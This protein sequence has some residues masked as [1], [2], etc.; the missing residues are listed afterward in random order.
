MMN[1]KDYELLMK[2]KQKKNIKLLKEVY[3]SNDDCL[4]KFEYG[5][6]LVNNGNR[7]EGK[8]ILLD[9]AQNENYWLAKLELGKLE[10]S[11]MNTKMARY[12]LESLLNTYLENSAFL[13]LSK[14]EYKI[15]NTEKSKGYLETL[16]GTELEVYAYILLIILEI[17]KHD[18]KKAVKTVNEA[19]SNGYNYSDQI[20][21][22]LSKKL[23]IFFDI[24]Y[25]KYYTS[26]YTIKQ[27]L[28]Y[29]E[30]LALS[31][32][33]GRHGG[34][35]FNRKINIK[36]LYVDIQKQLIKQNKLNF[37]H[38]NDIYVV[39]FENIGNQNEKYLEIVTLP[40]S[41][42]IITMFPIGS[43]YE[44]ENNDFDEFIKTI[45]KKH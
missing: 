42:E 44:A 28:S 1:D 10:I 12:Y 7:K 38:F 6:F 34:C 37:F 39:P 25:R 3:D 32:I 8:K 26:S 18:Y 17:K 14:L 45:S 33:I 27:I 30:S 36:K 11:D 9:L 23:N 41:N 22:F 31:L 24:E 43:L 4:T 13:E 21:V 5:K 29:D 35:D 20:I 15:G 16:I 2:A 40:N 19:L